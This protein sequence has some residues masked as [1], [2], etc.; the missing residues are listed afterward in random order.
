[1]KGDIGRELDDFAA[2]MRWEARRDLRRGLLLFVGAGAM[3]P[4]AIFVSSMFV[5]A[6]V[7]VGCV[8]LHFGMSGYGGFY[9]L[10]NYGGMLDNVRAFEAKVD[11]IG[12]EPDD[13][14]QS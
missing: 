11:A 6:I 5:L 9:A 3:V 12:D 2:K 10:K 8:A 1:M 4:L 14:R 13:E 7:V